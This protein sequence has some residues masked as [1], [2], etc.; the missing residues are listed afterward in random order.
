M[1]NAPNQDISPENIATMDWLVENV[2][3][4]IPKFDELTEEAQ[5]LVRLQGVD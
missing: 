2:I 4:D 5:A 1:H 3:G